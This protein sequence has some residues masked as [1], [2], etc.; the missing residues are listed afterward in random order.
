MED[1]CDIEGAISKK[2]QLIRLGNK[3]KNVI[4][5]VSSYNFS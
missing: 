3:I 4:N 2:K 5:E 1:T